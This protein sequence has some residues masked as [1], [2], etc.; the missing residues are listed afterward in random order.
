MKDDVNGFRVHCFPKRVFQTVLV[1]TVE[2]E[3][4]RG[5]MCLVSVQSA[6]GKRQKFELSA[7][8]RLVCFAVTVCVRACVRVLAS[9]FGGVLI[10]MRVPRHTH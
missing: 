7:G 10:L 2:Y 1:S 9:M 8:T 4:S 3:G 5:K 6:F